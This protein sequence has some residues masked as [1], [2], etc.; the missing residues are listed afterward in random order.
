MLLILITRMLQEPEDTIPIV[1]HF[2]RW[3]LTN[4]RLLLL[5]LLLWL[6]Y[7]INEIERKQQ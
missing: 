3:Y 5:F 6:S 1:R 2:L 4:E 7:C